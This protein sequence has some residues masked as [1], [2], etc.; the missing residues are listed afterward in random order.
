MTCYES[1]AQFTVQHRVYNLQLISAYAEYVC[2][3]NTNQQA[4]ARFDDLGIASDPFEG[5]L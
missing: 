4:I 1:L 3:L 5:P 2:L